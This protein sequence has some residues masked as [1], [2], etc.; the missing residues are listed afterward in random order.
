[1]NRELASPHEDRESMLLLYL[2]DELSPAERLRVER[3]LAGDAELST[4]L[5]ELREMQEHLESGLAAADAASFL[6]GSPAASARQFARSVKSWQEERSAAAARSAPPP[7]LRFPWWSYPLATAAAA[8]L[9]VV[10]W[11]KTLPPPTSRGPDDP[12]VQ[13][14]LNEQIDPAVVEDLAQYADITWQE[15]LEDS[16]AGLT[17]LEREVGALQTLRES[18]Q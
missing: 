9:A 13:L 1:M 5:S 16:A 11:W 10:V 7:Q 15:S 18:W 12:N 14:S 4:K 2:A 3:L 17:E 8:T 6:P